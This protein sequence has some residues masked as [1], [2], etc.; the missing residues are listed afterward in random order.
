MVLKPVGEATLDDLTGAD[1]IV[2]GSPTHFGG[3]SDRMKA[4]LDE[5]VK[6]RRRLE[7][8]V[9]AAFTSSGHFS[10]G[11]ETALLSMLQAL[12]IHGM[13][14]VGDPIETGGHYGVASVGAPDQEA[15]QACRALGRRVATV[16]SR[17]RGG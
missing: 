3:M 10:G 11:N 2:L 7:G 14:V 8:K 13:I 6:V 9:G 17:L 5:S 12:L 4:F 16:A 15:L 1:G